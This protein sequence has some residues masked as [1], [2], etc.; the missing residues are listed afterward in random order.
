[1]DL[2]PQFRSEPLDWFQSCTICM[3]QADPLTLWGQC[4]RLADKA[5]CTDCMFCLPLALFLVLFRQGICT[6][7]SMAFVLN[8]FLWTVDHIYRCLVGNCKSKEMVVSCTYIRICI[9]L[10]LSFDVCGFLRWAQFW[11]IKRFLVIISSLLLYMLVWWSL[12][13][14]YA[15]SI[16]VFVQNQWRLQPITSVILVASS[17]ICILKP[18][19]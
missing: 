4:A 12:C 5:L 6:G 18:L 13:E 1:M 10:A 14:D 7:L 19:E 15:I 16:F 9:C 2:S 3:H 8:E 17:L 11:Q